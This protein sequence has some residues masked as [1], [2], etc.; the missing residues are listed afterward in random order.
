MKVLLLDGS[1]YAAL[2]GPRQLE[3][4]LR[5]RLK[6]AVSDVLYL[7]ELRSSGA[8]SLRGLGLRVASLDC[9]EPAIRLH[10]SHPALSVAD[11]FALAVARANAWV[12]VAGSTA[13]AC[14][15]ASSGVSCRD[16]DW[17]A[18]EIE[19]RQAA[20]PDVQAMLRAS[21]VGDAGRAAYACAALTGPV[22]R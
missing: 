19:R 18:G 7:R 21:R 20:E 10:R 8:E 6:L 1:A 22:G 4:A 16:P 13:L 14:A 5:L 15:A 2:A 11:A 3:A 9:V 17:L 12:L